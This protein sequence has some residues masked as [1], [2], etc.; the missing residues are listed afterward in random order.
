[1]KSDFDPDQAATAEKNF[2]EFFR[3]WWF[4]VMVMVLICYTASFS[5]SLIQQLA[6]VHEAVAQGELWRLVTSQFVHLGFNHTMLNLVGYLIISASFREDVSP[7]QECTGLFASVI[8]VGLGIYY[9]SPEIQW[10]VGLSGA[11]YG[12][13]VFDLLLGWRRSPFLALFFSLFLAGKFVYEQLIA[14]PETV[15]AEFIGGLVAI[16]SHLY[17]AITGAL[18]GLIFLMFQKMRGHEQSGAPH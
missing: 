14:G 11:I 18:T 8:G 3:Q 13:L 4:S 15:S 16:D 5:N 1:M 12:L 9:L 2:N 6:L 10:Y 17:G 7:W